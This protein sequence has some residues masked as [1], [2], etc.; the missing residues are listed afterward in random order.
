MK[1]MLIIS[2]GLIWMLASCAPTIAEEILHPESEST[3][4]LKVAH[5]IETEGLT[6]TSP[7]NPTPI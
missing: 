6:M 4:D 2:I 3:P 1:K 5:A 7:I